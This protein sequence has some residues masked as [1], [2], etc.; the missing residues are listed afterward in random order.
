MVSIILIALLIFFALGV[1]SGVAA[2][3]FLRKKKRPVLTVVLAI[4]CLLGVYIP[5][6]FV[7]GF[8]VARAVLVLLGALVIYV[9]LM[10]IRETNRRGHN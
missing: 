9:I 8:M 6:Q 4:L 7:M 3:Y 2:I 5:V 1:I 10:V